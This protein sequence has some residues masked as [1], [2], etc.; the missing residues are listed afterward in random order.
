MVAQQLHPRPEHDAYVLGHTVDEFDRLIEQ[1]AFLGELTEHMLIH[2]GLG[3][4][5]HVLD[6]GCGAGDVQFLAARLVGAEGHVI[7]VGRRCR[8]QVDAARDRAHVAGLE[9]RRFPRR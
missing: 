5:I 4:G 6:I 8:S 3:H 1:A 9:Q 2:A 7:G